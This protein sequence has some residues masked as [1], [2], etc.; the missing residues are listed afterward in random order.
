VP[1][2]HRVGNLNGRRSAVDGGHVPFVV[3]LAGGRSEVVQP[4]DLIGAQLDAIGRSGLLD[5]GNPLGA[6][7]RGDVAALR[8][9]PGQ[10]D[11]CRCGAC[12]GC[13]R[14][15]L[16]DDAQI[17][18]EVLADEVFSGN[19][20]RPSSSVR[21]NAYAC[22]RSCGVAAVSEATR[23]RLWARASRCCPS[24]E[25]SLLRLRIASASAALNALT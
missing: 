13:N 17:A 2:Q 10:R 23:S 16:V 1:E 14:L 11:L 8:E 7:D 4:L 24:R 3:A 6:G 25:K 5:A 15:D 19:T 9:Q 21:A 12:L 20:M 18:L 22:S